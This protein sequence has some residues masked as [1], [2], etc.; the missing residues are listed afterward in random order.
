VLLPYRREAESRGIPLTA[1][2]VAQCLDDLRLAECVKQAL[3]GTGYRSLRSI[4]VAVNSQC[5]FLQGHVPSHYLKQ[6]AQATA[7]GVAGTHHVCNNL[8]VA[9]ELG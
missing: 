1:M 2:L 3:R 4:D 8:G 6:L 9:A 7:L 5:V